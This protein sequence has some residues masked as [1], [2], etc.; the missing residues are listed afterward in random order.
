MVSVARRMAF[1]SPS[2]VSV[3]FFILL[4]IGASASL[5]GAVDFPSPTTFDSHIARHHHSLVLIGLKKGCPKCNI[6]LSELQRVRIAAA[7]RN[8]NLLSLV[9]IDVREHKANVRDFD[10]TQV[11]TLLWFSRAGGGS[12]RAANEA[13]QTGRGIIRQQRIN[14]R[15]LPYPELFS[16][17]DLTAEGISAFLNDKLG[18]GKTSVL[19]NSAGGNVPEPGGSVDAAAGGEFVGVLLDDRTFYATVFNPDT[20]SLVL[21]CNGWNEECKALRSTY[22]RVSHTFAADP[23]VTVA[24]VDIDAHQ[25]LAM[26]CG[27]VGV[28]TMQYVERLIVFKFLCALFAL[29]VG[30]RRR[31]CLRLLHRLF[32]RLRWFAARGQVLPPRHRR[33]GATRL[34]PWLKT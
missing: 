1:L 12:A 18:P 8:S 24:A 11:P 15:G 17:H 32:E 20:F 31:S 4:S 2:F 21:F 28:P 7:A 6:L 33:Q 14:S 29:P 27:V 23:R 16:G 26:N 9:A 10:V 13:L 19:T 25:E 5:V 3:F 34:Y 22:A 30:T